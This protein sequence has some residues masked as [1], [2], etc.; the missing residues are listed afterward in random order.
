MACDPSSRRGGGAS[1]WLR[2]R[3]AVSTLARPCQRAAPPRIA[4]ACRSPARPACPN[5]APRRLALGLMS[6]T[7]RDGIDAA[8]LETDGQTFCA[9]GALDLGR[10]PGRLPPAPGRGDRRHRR[11]RAVERE[12]TDRH[13]EAVEALLAKAGVPASDG[14]RAGLPRAYGG[15]RPGASLY[16]ADRRRGRGWHGRPGSTWSPI[17]AWPTWPRAGKGRRSRRTTIA[18]GRSGWTGRWPCSTWAGSATLPGW[19]AVRAD[20]GVRYRSRERAV[21]RSGRRAHRPG[22]RRT[23]RAVRRGPGQPVRARRRML[24]HP[25]FD[26]APPKS[27]DRDDFT[28]DAVARLADADAAAT[29]AAFHRRKRGRRA[30]ASARAAAALAGHGR[31]PAQPDPDAH[32]GRAPGRAGR[33]G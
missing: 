14:A 9:G 18:P 6:G 16:P 24:A 5:T 11:H 26:R 23:R 10:L 8:L 32:A 30:P 20:P 15:A 2:R 28:G 19:A 1:G 4:R 17:S 13:A 7:S 12:L 25:F 3:G 31:R 21:G 29:L 33:A 27:L 22:L